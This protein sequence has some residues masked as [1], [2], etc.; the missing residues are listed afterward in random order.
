MRKNNIEAFAQTNG[1]DVVASWLVLSFPDQAGSGLGP[2]C[3][4]L[5]RTVLSLPMGINGE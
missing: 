1:G 2:L 5:T 3:C 4:V